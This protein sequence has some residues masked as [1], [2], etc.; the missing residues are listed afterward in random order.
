MMIEPIKSTYLSQ[1]ETVRIER[2]IELFHFASLVKLLDKIHSI[3][4]EY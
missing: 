2:R 3:M 4:Q 1:I